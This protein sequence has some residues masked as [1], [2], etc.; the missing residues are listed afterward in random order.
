MTTKYETS[1]VPIR[2][3]WEI[4]DIMVSC[5]EAGQLGWMPFSIDYE[6]GYIFF[7]RKI[8]PD[9]ETPENYA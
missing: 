2:E 6:R 5:D 9:R 1:V 3:S 8:D 4:S 7:T